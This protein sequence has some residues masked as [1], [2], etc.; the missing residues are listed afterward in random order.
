MKRNLLF[1]ATLVVALVTFAG[2]LSTFAATP[3]T[4]TPDFADLLTPLV[5]PTDLTTWET[6]KGVIEDN[7]G[8]L[9][10][11]FGALDNELTDLLLAVEDQSA[12][13]VVNELDGIDSGTPF[14][15]GSDVGEQAEWCNYYIDQLQDDID[16]LSNNV[17]ALEIGYDD[18]NVDKD[19]VV[20][21]ENKIKQELRG[22]QAELEALA[23]TK[24]GIVTALLAVYNPNRDPYDATGGDPTNPDGDPYLNPYACTGL[25]DDLIDLIGSTGVNT[26]QQQLV[27]GSI[28]ELVNQLIFE[29]E[30]AA[31]LTF[32]DQFIGQ[33]IGLL[34]PG[35]ILSGIN[36]EV[37]CLANPLNLAVNEQ[38]ANQQVF[39]FSCPDWYTATSPNNPFPFGSVGNAAA[40]AVEPLSVSNTYATPNP[41]SFAQDSQVKFVAEGK[42]IAEVQV[43]VYDLAG[44]VVYESGYQQG[45]ALSW[46]LLNNQGQTVANGV[47]LYVVTAQG[48][49]GEVVRGQVQKLVVLK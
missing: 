38:F 17:D 39:D 49:N 33:F 25:C 31:G 11:C 26:L 19:T 6:A 7:L 20:Y 34:T 41:A 32:L 9:A 44:G 8:V 12:A 2:G 48:S 13:V 18:V 42:G 45:N 5:T 24:D 21:V 23:G 28:E 3:P 47:Y 46:N 16:T 10:D 40:L 14:D 36:F 22:V 4:S 15:D 43:Q 37:G 35:S 1:L 30:V 29:K 27:W